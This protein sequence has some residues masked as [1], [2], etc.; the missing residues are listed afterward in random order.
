M[1]FVCSLRLV[2]THL[3]PLH[4]LT[5]SL[6]LPTT[7]PGQTY[8]VLRVASS[9]LLL[10][11]LHRS[12]SCLVSHVALFRLGGCKLPRALNSKA[13]TASLRQP[14]RVPLD[15]TT[16]TPLDLSLHLDSKHTTLN[17]TYA[18]PTTNDQLYDHRSF[19]LSLHLPSTL[20]PLLTL[21]PPPSTP[22][23]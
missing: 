2:S 20:L 6:A 5:H 1:G 19:P 9:L 18:T 14:A 15:H 21:H 16:T 22:S 7:T 13:G 8:R 12:S 10:L 4:S 23:P 3:C 17:P 11:L